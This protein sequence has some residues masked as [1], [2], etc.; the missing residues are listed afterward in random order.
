MTALKMMELR[1]PTNIIDCIVQP[2]KI[3]SEPLLLRTNTPIT[4]R[5]HECED[6]MEKEAALTYC[7]FGQVY[8]QTY[9]Y[10][11]ILFMRVKWPIDLNIH[12]LFAAF[13]VGTSKKVF[14]CTGWWQLVFPVGGCEANFRNCAKSQRGNC[15]LR[16]VVGKNKTPIIRSYNGSKAFPTPFV[17]SIQPVGC[18][19]HNGLFLFSLA[20]IKSRHTPI[21]TTINDEENI[22]SAEILQMECP[23]PSMWTLLL[24]NKQIPAEPEP[25]RKSMKNK[26]RHGNGCGY[27]FYAECFLIFIENERKKGEKLCD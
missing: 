12:E 18:T 27:F 17:A 15:I 5:S 10:L 16:G 3:E 13:H 24:L 14:A 21:P 20:A 11:F 25:K 19:H 1:T 26:L 7:R 2:F 4:F 23:P 9:Q 6:V 22:P 8:I